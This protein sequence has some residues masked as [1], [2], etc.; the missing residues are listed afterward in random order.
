MDKPKFSFH[1]TLVMLGF[2]LHEFFANEL[3]TDKGTSAV[4]IDKA[5][6]AI[7]YKDVIYIHNRINKAL[8]L[9][10]ETAKPNTIPKFTAFQ[11]EYII[12]H[13]VVIFK[14]LG[15]IENDFSFQSNDSVKGEIVETIN[16][17]VDDLYI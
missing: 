2:C 9:I 14:K 8:G 12:S 6:I 7:G 17:C 5:Y 16:S 13:I 15:Y 10:Q 3:T 1:D 4:Q 11:L